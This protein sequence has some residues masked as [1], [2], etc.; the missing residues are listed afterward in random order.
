MQKIGNTT[1]SATPEGEFTNGSA[2]QGIWSTSIEA[3]WL[4]TIQ[5]ELINVVEGAEL[6]LDP[7]DDAQMAKA[8]HISSIKSPNFNQDFCNAIGGYPK[9]SI[10]LS[11]DGT[12]LWQSTVEANTTDPDAPDS[13]GW[14][15]GTIDGK[16]GGVLEPD[17]H[18]TVIAKS[19][20]TTPGQTN[21]SPSF[22]VKIRD[23]HFGGIY[24]NEIY[25]GGARV[26]IGVHYAGAATVYQFGYNGVA[27]AP[28]SWTTSSDKRIKTEIKVIDHAVEK[29]SKIRGCT[30][31]KHGTPLAG[32][33]AQDVEAVLPEAVTIVPTDDFA[34]LK[35]VDALGILGLCIAAV[36]ELSQQVESLELRIS[37]NT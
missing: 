15:K 36:N 11:T 30:F 6:T 24:Y 2:A 16:K 33:I 28:V 12:T 14:S 32:V 21:E 9:G 31:T 20:G 22:A 25:G 1:P 29:L 17:S 35:C 19:Y 8:V 4:N 5:R 10:L 26:I 27:T 18:L 34:D 37:K 7:T 13:A 3:D 23:G